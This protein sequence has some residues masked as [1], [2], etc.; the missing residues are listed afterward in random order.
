MNINWGAAQKKIQDLI[1]VTG[2]WIQWLQKSGSYSGSWD[3]GSTLTYGYGDI[4]NY[5]TTGSCQALIVHVTAEEAVKEIGYWTEDMDRIFV[6]PSSTIEHW[7]QVI[8][9]SGSGVRYLI[10]PLHDAYAG[11]AGTIISKS[12]FVRRLVP[13]S[14]SFY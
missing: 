9:P 6:D 4:I 14:G 1:S 8:I 7:D 3:S 11:T 5:W 10:L 2:T 13:K 12:A